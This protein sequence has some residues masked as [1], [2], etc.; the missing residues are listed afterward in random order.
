LLAHIHMLC[1]GMQR[2][3]HFKLV[4]TDRLIQ[5]GLLLN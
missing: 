4:S 3:M 1:T 5:D 2:H